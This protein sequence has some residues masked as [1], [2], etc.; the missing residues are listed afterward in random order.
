M[1]ATVMWAGLALAQPTQNAAPTTAGS[2]D[3]IWGLK[4]P[5]RDGVRLSGTVFKPAG[6]TEPLPVIFTLTP[7]IAD[8]L[9]K[10]ARPISRS[11]DTFSCLVDMRGRGNSEGIFEPFAQEAEDGHDVVEFLAQP[12]VVATA[13]SP[14][15][16]A[17]TRA[18]TNGRRLKE[19]PPHLA[20]ARS[21]GISSRRSWTPRIYKGIWP[22]YDDAVAE[23]SPAAGRAMIQPL[24]ARTFVLDREV[25]ARLYLGERP[26]NTL[27][28]LV[29]NT[30]TVFQEW[31]Q[32]PALRCLLGQ[33]MAPTPEQYAEDECPHPH[34]HRR[35][36]TADQPGADVVL[37]RAHE[38]RQRRDQGEALPHHRSLGPS[39][40]ANSEERKSEGS[41]SA[42]PACST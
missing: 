38:V 29:G 36:T 11:M 23:P 31:L 15:G 41:P 42:T 14:C 39:R 40:N 18:S 17:L 28:Q 3:L 5:M 20:S 21:R 19:L 1:F 24:S 6:Q 12:A 33:A 32:H 30:A 16:E 35:I 2:S 22:S 9:I 27:D 7:Y 10:T 8:W 25:S 4:I 26:F 13:R 37:S 34:H